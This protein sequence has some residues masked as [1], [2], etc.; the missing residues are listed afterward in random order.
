[1]SRSSGSTCGARSRKAALLTLLGLV[2]AVFPLQGGLLSTAFGASSVSLPLTASSIPLSLGFSP[3]SM[4]PVS[5]G[6]PV[7]SVGET[8]WVLSGFNYSVP[9]SLTSARPSAH[10]STA[11]V[12]VK[13]LEPAAVAP[14]YS[15]GS[16]DV[17]GLWNVTVTTLSGS[18]VVP[19]RFVNL[20]DHPVSLSPLAYS[21][22][23][24]N[25]SISS[26]ASLGDSYDQQVCAVGPSAGAG[27][28]I[29]FPA[30]M[31]PSGNVTLVLGS[32]S[33]V[34]RAMGNVTQPFS[35]WFEL[36]HPYSLDVTSAN[37]LVVNNL[38]AASSQPVAFASQ[39]SANATLTWTAPMREGRYELRSY[40]QNST[41]LE[42]VQSDVLIASSTSWVS[43]SN[44]CQPE[45][46]SSQSVSY[47]A[48][49]A[50]GPETW[51]KTLYLMYRS[52]GVEGVTSYP[53]NAN[54]ASVSFLASPWNKTVPDVA[55]NVSPAPNLVQTSQ[56]GSTLYVLAS[57][58]PVSLS[59]S[60]DISGGHDLVQN[61]LT[62]DNA[63]S[64][65]TQRV[66]LAKLTVNVVSD[67]SAP[68]N[69]EI[70][71]PQGVN[72]AG[73]LVGSNQTMSFLLPSGS[74]S[75]TATQAGNVQGTDVALT[76][77]VASV[78]TLNFNTLMSF[79]II[80]IVTAALAAIANVM[81]WVLRGRSLGSRMTGSKDTKP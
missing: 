64:T 52:F 76:D 37:S 81:I 14:L 17:D 44:A 10:S 15:F 66:S 3:S 2:L 51:P 25:L 69:L 58:F 8:I 73:G 56:E 13:M 71:G 35:F 29:N 12:A 6:V 32:S 18:V 53:V 21:L 39:G 33:V 77:G 50:K 79:E 40:F 41:D 19:V 27:L 65:Q 28:G 9:V 24:G 67:Q 63:Y 36:Y 49:L 7:Y 22:S 31:Q 34:V 23:G 5:Q 70:T 1:L 78:V 42:L 45:T 72:V 59:Y 30:G 16:G 75:L 20:A 54:I 61:S 57:S 62:V 47:S 68:T 55:V 80:L 46:L 48:S 74:Y 43:L 60:L 38:Q 11:I 26:Q 4:A